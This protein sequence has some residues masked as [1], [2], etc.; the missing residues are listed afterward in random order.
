VARADNLA[1]ICVLSNMLQPYRTPRPV[2]G[3]AL[4]LTHYKNVVDVL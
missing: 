2:M 3:I 1:T 4:F